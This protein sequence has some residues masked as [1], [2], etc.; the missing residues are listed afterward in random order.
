M[1][2]KFPRVKGRVGVSCHKPKGG[3]SNSRTNVEIDG[4]WA[5]VIDLQKRCQMVGFMMMQCGASATPHP[6]IYLWLNKF[7]SRCPG[8]SERA[9]LFQRLTTSPKLLGERKLSGSHLQDVTAVNE[10]VE[11]TVLL[12][13]IQSSLTEE[14]STI[15]G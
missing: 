15:A 14:Q 7:R 12:R 11:G 6:C 5:S 3:F 1:L 13:N 8:S 10:V 9:T 4:S 2:W